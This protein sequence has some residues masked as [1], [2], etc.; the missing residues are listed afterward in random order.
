MG[1]TK[2][3]ASATGSAEAEKAAASPETAFPLPPPTLGFLIG[4]LYLQGAMAMGLLPHPSTHK[5]ESQP[6]QA[7]H[8][9][10]LLAMLQEKTE[11]NRTPDETAELNGALHEL[12]MAYVRLQNPGTS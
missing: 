3:A 12:R 9:I 2:A 10:D 1:K 7:R 5:S 11:G 6:A 8:A 4:T